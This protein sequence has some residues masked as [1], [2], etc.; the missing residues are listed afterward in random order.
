MIPEFEPT[1]NLTQSS[2]MEDWI[3]RQTWRFAKH[4]LLVVNFFMAIFIGLPYLAPILANYGYNGAALVIYR[5]YKVTCHQLPSLALHFW[6]PGGLVSSLHSYLGRV[7]H[8]RAGLCAA[9]PSPQRASLSLVDIGHHP[10]RT[11]RRH[12]VDGASV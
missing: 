7:F 11:G 12:A 8:R 6:T 10:R 4:W 1:Q 9:A 3:N 5:A 2:A